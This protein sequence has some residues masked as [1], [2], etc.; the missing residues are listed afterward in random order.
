MNNQTIELE[1]YE[2]VESFFRDY[3]NKFNQ[4]MWVWLA[5]VVTCFALLVADFVITLVFQKDFLNAYYFKMGS[6]AAT[7]VSKE[8]PNVMLNVYIYRVASIV[9]YILIFAY[10]IYSII[11]YKV[12]ANKNQSFIR[13]NMWLGILTFVVAIYAVFNLIQY[14]YNNALNQYAPFAI[15]IFAI[16]LVSSILYILIYFIPA[17][18]VRKLVKYNVFV[19]QNIQFKI[20]QKKFQE[21]Q[22]NGGSSPFD[23]FNIFNNMA[24]EFNANAQDAS[25]GN[26]E[27]EDEIARQ[28]HEAKQKAAKKELYNP[29][30]S[31]DEEKDKAM[32]KL[33]SMPNQQLF[34][35]AAILNISGYEDMS[36]DELASLIYNYTKQAQERYAQ[37]QKEIHQDNNDKK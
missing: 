3:K 13:Q 34:E 8:N 32:E 26:S 2:T 19:V 14:M 36:K 24:A 22:A 16:E 25:E 21:S 15:A 6:S 7:Q 11:S 1:K 35:M 31:M 9:V 29:A 20:I 10:L 18:Q 33:L 12:T 30:T 27:E 4:W 5:C 23:I 17:G 37:T 28:Y